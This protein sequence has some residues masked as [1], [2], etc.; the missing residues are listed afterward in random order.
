MAEATGYSIDT[1]ANPRLSTPSPGLV[2][3]LRRRHWLIEAVEASP[4]GTLVSLAC[5]DDDHQGE[6]LEVLWEAAGTRPL[7]RPLATFDLGGL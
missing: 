4:G 7:A 5:L 1:P 6:P 2:A 3:H